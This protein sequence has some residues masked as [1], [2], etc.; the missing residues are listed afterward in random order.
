MSTQLF[1]LPAESIRDAHPGTHMLGGENKEGTEAT[2][3]VQKEQG[4]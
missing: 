4:G 2:R 1:A 3:M